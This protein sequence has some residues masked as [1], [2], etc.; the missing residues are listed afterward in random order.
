MAKCQVPS[1]T[2]VRMGLAWLDRGLIRPYQEPSIVNVPVSFCMHY[3]SNA[4]K[5][6]YRMTIR[7]GLTRLD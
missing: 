6:P 3:A 4:V 2:T 7:M 1:Q 5:S